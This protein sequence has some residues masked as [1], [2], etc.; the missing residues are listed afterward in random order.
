MLSA[1]QK[2]FC[3]EY[4]NDYNGAR[5][6][7]AAGWAEIGAHREASRQLKKQEVKDYIAELQKAIRDRLFI[8]ADRVISEVA[9][10]A[11]ANIKD[12]VNGENR[13]LELKHLPRH[14]TAAVKSIKTRV[15]IDAN[16]IETI[17]TELS[18]HDK[19][20][21]IDKLMKHLGMFEKDNEQKAINI[22]L[23]KEQIKQIDEA[24]ENG[25]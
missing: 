16:G 22:N 24:L 11:F 4:V 5:S 6:A 12:F 13:V 7:K 17:H 21:Q 10:V 25:V 1:R 15:T 20:D 23:S 9:S 2:I 8:S 3:E 18:L 14:I 19:P